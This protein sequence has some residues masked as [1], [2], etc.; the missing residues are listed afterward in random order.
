MTALELLQEELKSAREV[1][2]G[3][4]G[5][6]TSEQ[7][8]VAPGGLAIPL[9]ATYAHMVLS[10]DMLIHQMLQK[11]EPLM[12]GEWKEKTGVDKP[13]PP[14]DANYETAN[15]EWSAA[16][17]V[18]LELLRA[19]QAAVFAATEEYISGL[20]DADLNTEV[21]MGDWG[22]YTVG[23]FIGN[24]IIGHMWSLTG[25]ISALKGLQG[26]KGYPF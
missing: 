22:K 15:R 17:K 9:G 26:V 23:T 11:K 13:M 3:T 19:Y 2:M 8:H 24:L 5:D 6:I 21:D 14:W 16:V 10:E 12:A 20:S 1:F 25:E 7:L 18:D 4:A